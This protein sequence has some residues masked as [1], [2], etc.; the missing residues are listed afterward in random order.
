[1]SE[2]KSESK[3]KDGGGAADISAAM[4]VDSAVMEV[5]KPGG[6]EGTGWFITFAG[7]S[8]E[9]TLAWAEQASRRALRRQA[10]IEQAQA[11]GRKWRPEDRAPADV[12]RDNVEW[13]VARILDWSPVKIGG[14]IIGFS[15]A[16]AIELLLRPDMGWAFAQA[17]EFLAGET[18]F[19][20]PSATN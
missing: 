4:P 15:E 10:A 8:H 14:E 5:M 19:T 13:I 20:R 3:V 9:K 11:N 16:A 17:V 18:S 12:R 1:M 7:P 6:V 2:S